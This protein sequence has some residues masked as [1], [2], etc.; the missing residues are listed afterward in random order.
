MCADRPPRGKDVRRFKHCAHGADVRTVAVAFTSWRASMRCK[1]APRFRRAAPFQIAR[2]HLERPA[3]RHIR[4]V[5]KGA[6]SPITSATRRASIRS[7][8]DGNADTPT[9]Y[10]QPRV[11]LVHSWGLAT[12]KF[13]SYGH[14]DERSRTSNSE[15]RAT[16]ITQPGARRRPIL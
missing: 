4:R 6:S 5:A 1:C 10:S 7:S 11:N 2:R 13:A 15:P 16:L 12:V 8:D 3:R 9:T 14:F